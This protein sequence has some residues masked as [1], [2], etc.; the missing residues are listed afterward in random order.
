MWLHHRTRSSIGQRVND[1]LG[2]RPIFASKDV[3]QSG[4]QRA[5]VTGKLGQ[6]VDVVVIG[7]FQPTREDV[8]AARGQNTGKVLPCSDEVELR[9]RTVDVDL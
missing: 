7:E 6:R 2:D 8:V 9:F 1:G 5:E 4:E 3:L